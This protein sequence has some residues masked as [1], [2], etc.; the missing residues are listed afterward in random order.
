MVQWRARTF[1]TA[2]SDP[3]D[4]W[5]WPGETVGRFRSQPPSAEYLVR[6]AEVDRGGTTVL[7]LFD[8]EA[9]FLTLVQTSQIPPSAR[10]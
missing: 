7:L 1:G 3:R 9:D 10:R 4:V 5:H 2:R 8:L 6:L